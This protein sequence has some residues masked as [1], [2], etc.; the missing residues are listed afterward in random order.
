MSEQ[1]G[2]EEK[3]G[4]KLKT[5]ASR[6]VIGRQAAGAYNARK[7]KWQNLHFEGTKFIIGKYQTFRILKNKGEIC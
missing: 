5:I 1:G 6:V 7:E 2:E 4:V 3:V